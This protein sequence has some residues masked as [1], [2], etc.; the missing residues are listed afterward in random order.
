M[1]NGLGPDSMTNVVRA[2]GQAVGWP[3][4]LSTTLG[5]VV[6]GQV[7]TRIECLLWKAHKMLVSA[8]L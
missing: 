4:L 5:L 1:P 2:F 3:S 7:L 6:S 8:I